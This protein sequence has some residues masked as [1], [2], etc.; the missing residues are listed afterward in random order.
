MTGER[1]EAQRRRVRHDLEALGRLAGVSGAVPLVGS[2]EE[3]DNEFLVVT[4]W[5]DG[6]SIASLLTGDPLPPADAEELF[7]AMVRAAA[8]VHR[9]GVIHR[10]LSPRCAHLM[11]DGRVVLTDFDYSRIPE[12]AVGF[13]DIVRG[14][15]EGE[16]LAPEIRADPS[17]ARKA[18]D[19]WSLA[20][21]GLEVFGATVTDITRVP[22]KW[23]TA[24]KL[25]L[26]TDPDERTEDAELLLAQLESP[27]PPAALLPDLQP[28][29]VLEDRWVVRAH[30]VGQG[31]ISQVYRVFDT[32]TVR[33]YAAKFVRSQYEGEI[34]PSAE[35]MLLQD[36]PQ[37]PYI[38][39]PELPQRI[40]SVRRGN[41]RFERKAVFL[42]TPWVDGTRLD[43]LIGEHV[44]PA[45]VMELGVNIAEA[46]EHLHRNGIIHRD[47][48]PQNVLLNPADGTPRLVD[49]N[50]SRYETE[51]TNT[52]TG[53]PKYRAP[54]LPDAGWGKDSD[55]FGLGYIMSELLAG[56]PLGITSLREWLDIGEDEVFQR[57]PLV[58]ELLRKATAGLR[59]QRYE[60]AA[61]FQADA[62][63]AL[64][65]LRTASPS[66]G[67][68]FPLVPADDEPRS[69]W[70]P[71]LERLIGLF[72]QSK[73]SNAGTRGLDPFSRWAYVDT[74]ID[75]ELYLRIMSGSLRFVII[76]GNA[77]DG[78]TA[79]IQMVETRLQRDEGATV[80]RR[81]ASN[82]IVATL[83]GRRL[84][85]NWDGSQ[86]EGT[87]TSDEV[88]LDFF[89]PLGGVT[90]N[91]AE[92]ETRIVAIN[93]GRLLDFLSAFRDRFPWLERVVAGLFAGASEDVPDWIA[94]VNL[95]LRALTVA[96]NGEASIPGRLLGKFADPRLWAACENC[97]ARADC[98]ARAN[99]AVL[100]DP[101]LGPRTAERVRQVLDVVRLRRR[102]HITM[103]DLRSAL[104]FMV[105]GNRTCDQIVAIVESGDTKP[106]VAGHIYNSL[107]AASASGGAELLSRSAANDRLLNEVG[108]ID[109]ARTADPDDDARLWALG[110]GALRPDPVGIDRTDR[111]LLEELRLH[112]PISGPELQTGVVRNEIRFI[113]TSLRRK[114]FL[115]REDPAWLSMLPLSRLSQFTRQLRAA[116]PE[117]RN[118]LAS[119]VSASEGLKVGSF[120][121]YIAVRLAQEGE[122]GDRSFVTHEVS[123]FVVE[124]V[125]LRALARY[126]EYQPDLLVLR[127][128]V[129]DDIRLEVDVDL[130]ESLTR[131]ADGF[132]PSR[133]ELR[134]AW[135][136]LRIFKEHL[137]SMRSDSL[138]VIRTDGDAY[139]I[140]RTSS[141]NAIAARRVR[142]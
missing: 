129:R 108:Y 118:A 19:V 131:I 36:V 16:Y 27:A 41:S 2:V 122:G 61:T 11:L 74:Q 28:N 58:R 101:V 91:P 37:H 73:T 86:D 5:P 44:P 75:R 17:S 79:F 57:A 20:R 52:V 134:G 89:M 50:V 70:N 26:A 104:A 1:A 90:P 110:A 18:S 63:K 142:L 85:T 43:D 120:P 66:E 123:E 77:G 95:N 96:T 13:T 113:H 102:L 135:L 25:A 47:L 53:T 99:A 107:F 111:L 56:R 32:L 12:S 4:P 119:A 15:F 139:R 132:T 105:A 69:N 92:N 6:E 67:D 76:T 103:R 24:V 51:A 48:K 38:V 140:A 60:S 137:A 21:I 109:V 83:G 30:P 93:E 126:V 141:G 35:F 128:K 106:I 87:R 78:K 130:Y 127:H 97:S 46:L 117:D 125:N 62:R 81:G 49:F 98:Y 14:E 121:D 59:G 72:S 45:R 64:E 88:L 23:H 114:L 68:D 138:L 84:E 29:D 100:A 40:S 34:D 9:A 3:L 39:R 31:G 55:L 42:P 116:S 7:I 124:P 22:E 54:D 33:D 82:G 115:E 136:N 80:A 133:E 65:Q 8:S 10:N 94:V 71:Y 112:L